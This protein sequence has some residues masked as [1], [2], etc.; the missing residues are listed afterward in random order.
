MWFAFSLALPSV[1]ISQ[2]VVFIFII[3]NPVYVFVSVCENAG[4]LG[5][6]KHL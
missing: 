5:G 1:H 3:F 6:Q 2:I 4:A